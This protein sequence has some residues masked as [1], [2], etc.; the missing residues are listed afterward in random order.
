VTASAAPVVSLTP[1]LERGA[2]REAV[3]AFRRAAAS[4][5]RM[6]ALG[7]TTADRVT[8]AAAIAR[9]EGDDSATMRQ[10]V[11]DDPDADPRGEIPAPATSNAALARAAAR[12]ATME[13]AIQVLRGLDRGDLV[14]LVADEHIFATRLQRA[15]RD[16]RP[17]ALLARR[18]VDTRTALTSALESL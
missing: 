3:A 8:Q 10:P 4:V 6:N 13:E 9:T 7:R 12:T 1:L 5:R 17:T 16:G 15:R 18:L 2:A 11:C 14:R